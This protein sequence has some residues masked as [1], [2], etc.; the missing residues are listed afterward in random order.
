M[1]EI[2]ITPDEVHVWKL[3]LTGKNS[4]GLEYYEALLS[5]D[6]IDR[7]HKLRFEEDRK[8]FIL[9]RGHLRVLLSKYLNKKPRQIW[10]RYGRYGK[11]YLSEESNA[12]RINFNLSHSQD[13]VIYAVAMGRE[14]G[15]DI[16]HVRAVSR[17]D[18]IIDRFFSEEEKEFYKG[19]SEDDRPVR[20]FKLWCA[21]EAYTKAIGS[22]ISLPKDEIDVSLVTGEFIKENGKSS[23]NPAVRIYEL[24]V[25]SG[26]LSYLAV[27]GPEPGIIFQDSI[28]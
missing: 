28:D 10:L 5:E 13:T 17:A 12:E 2:T 20:F 14:V 11:P 26:Y 4:G 23:G 21:R 7:A 1:A 24:S 27:S 9:A 22:G 18:K 3:N 16:E 15:I 6:E 8:R 25:D 19:A